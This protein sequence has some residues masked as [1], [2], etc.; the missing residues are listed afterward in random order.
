MLGNQVELWETMLAAMKLGAVIIPATTAARPR[1]PAR[2]RRAR[3]GPP[4]AWPRGDSTPKFDGRARATTRG[5]PSAAASTGWLA[6][7]RRATARA[8]TSTPDGVDHGAD[9]PLLLYFTSGT[10]AKPKLVE[11]TQASYPVGHLS[12]MY[13]IGLQP[14]DVHLNITS[15]GWA[16]HA[17]SCFFAPWNAGATVLIYNYARFDAGGRCS[18]RWRAAA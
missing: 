9:D 6:L 8:A 10:T 13:W 15:P 14:G 18:T 5:S 11:H 17:W 7:R 1:R 12:T 4:R 16:K 3:R 2:P